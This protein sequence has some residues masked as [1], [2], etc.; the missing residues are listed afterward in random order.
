MKLILSLLVA[1]LIF[2]SAYAK[3]YNFDDNTYKI[4]T[5]QSRNIMIPS[6]QVIH[7]RLNSDVASQENTKNEVITT[8]LMQDWIYMGKVIAPEGSLISGRIT[9][10][11]NSSY[12]S[13]NAKVNI[14]FYQVVRPDDVTINF[15]AKPICVTIGESRL[16]S[17]SKLVW[18][19]I[20]KSVLSSSSLSLNNIAD[21]T[22]TGAFAGGYTFLSTRGEE[23]RIP[24]GTEFRINITS[25]I[26]TVT[27]DN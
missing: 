20:K 2:G 4:Y 27:Y 16:K 23:V 19:G 14:S 26:N 10:I 21:N 7:S 5:Q 6:G 11:E 22:I 15:Q 12:A 1:V 17:G 25:T 8:Q 13:G 3:E 24:F 9:S 18:E